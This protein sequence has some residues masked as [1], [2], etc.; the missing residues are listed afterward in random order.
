MTHPTC[1]LSAFL[2]FMSHSF[3]LGIALF[4]SF[5]FQHIALY[6]AMWRHYLNMDGSKLRCKPLP[7]LPVPSCSD[8]ILGC[9]C[10][11]AAR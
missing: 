9:Y 1:Y 5:V 7:Q 11:P 10:K 3:T 8:C 4:N 6:S 2:A